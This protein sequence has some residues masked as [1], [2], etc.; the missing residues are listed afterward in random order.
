[1]DQR[2]ERGGPYESCGGV[3]GY[4]AFKY[5]RLYDYFEKI[6]AYKGIY[7]LDAERINNTKMLNVW[8]KTVWMKTLYT[9]IFV[10]GVQENKFSKLSFD[11][12]L[13][14]GLKMDSS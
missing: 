4:S 8:M 1:M 13:Q 5:D 11:R 12:L 9:N 14:R 3:S 2:S 10:T 7:T 6:H